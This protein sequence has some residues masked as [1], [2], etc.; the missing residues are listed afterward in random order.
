[1]FHNHAPAI[2]PVVIMEE[3]V[4]GIH[5]IEDL[6]DGLYLVTL[7][8]RQRSVIDGTWEHIIA[9]RLSMSHRDATAMTFL[10]A[11]N[12]GLSVF[13]AV[14]GLPKDELAH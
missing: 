2:E 13:G 11:K 1:M 14:E 5:S 10:M 9:G 3:R 6:G 4:S 7:Y 8:K 12:L